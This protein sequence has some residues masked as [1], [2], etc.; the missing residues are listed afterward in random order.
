MV[1][2]RVGAPSIAKGL[3]LEVAFANISRTAF[4][5]RAQERLGRIIDFHGSL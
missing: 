1:V 4:R 3:D 2:S 5:G